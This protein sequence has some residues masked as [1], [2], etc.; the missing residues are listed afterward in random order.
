MDIMSDTPKRNRVPTSQLIGE[1]P[2]SDPLAH[3]QTAGSEKAQNDA[4][5]KSVV[6]YSIATGP[7]G[8]LIQLLILNLH[9]T[10]IDVGLAVTLF[11]AVSVPAAVFWGFATDRFH[12]RKPI[13][14]ASYLATAAVLFLFLFAGTVYYV[15]F[16][17]ALFSF[18]TSAVTTPLNLLVME[19]SPKQ[20]WSS[21]FAWFS[22]VTSIGQTGGLILG[23]AW[24][25]FLLLSY[26]VIPL[27]T[28][29]LAS[30]GLSV[31]M[32]KEPSLVFERQ[33]MA[34][35][36]HSFFERLRVIPYV[37]LRIPKLSDFK[38]VFR[39][40][41]YDLTRNVPVLYFSIFMFY[42]GSGLFNTSIVPALSANGIP[43]LPIFF[44]T[45][46]VFVVQIIAFRY[47]GPYAEK[48]SLTGASI[49]G[50]AVRS[51]GY[52]LLGVS[53]Y[54]VPGLWYI[55]P[56]LILYPLAAGFAYSIYYTASN[57]MVFNTLGDRHSGSSLG[58]YSALVGIATMTGSLISGFTSF[59]LG[60]GVTF[61]LAGMCLAG[62]I[63]LTSL[64]RES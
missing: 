37:F 57:T 54:F 32:L 14:I 19:N 9:G 17:Y 36:R 52:V 25:S 30:A 51:A 47:A 22:M 12:R 26:L 44:V 40:L 55:V 4:W 53:M 59:Y 3:S 7:V 62:S 11:S 43:N 41:K 24:S 50:L 2:K 42:I 13:I 63:W 56:A 6:P 34:L 64:L 8:T 23:T 10:V 60:F 49:Y 33:M 35:N 21:A 45:T 48:K 16:L 1:S 58:V 61:I 31:T 18:V 20:K 38:R 15:S 28:L 39:S 27:A 29:S 5:V 46:T